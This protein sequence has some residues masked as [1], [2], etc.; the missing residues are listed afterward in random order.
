MGRI[1]ESQ[2][3]VHTEDDVFRDLDSKKKFLK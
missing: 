2:T 3:K 1:K